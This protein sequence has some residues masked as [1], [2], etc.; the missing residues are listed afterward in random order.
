MN[1]V[2]RCMTSNLLLTFFLVTYSLYKER[3]T[4]YSRPV[5]W[6][7]NQPQVYEYI[8]ATFAYVLAESVK[9]QVLK[10][11]VTSAGTLA[12]E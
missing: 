12:V 8:D 6:I 10:A 7:I 2:K 3:Q 11:R 5:S 1:E 9:L 4:I